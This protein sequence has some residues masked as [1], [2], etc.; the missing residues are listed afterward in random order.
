MA[1][2]CTACTKPLIID[3]KFCF[4]C[5]EFDR[6]YSRGIFQ[7]IY[8]DGRSDYMALCHNDKIFE[9]EFGHSGKWLMLSDLRYKLNVLHVELLKKVIKK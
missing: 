4:S 6:K 1:F 8:N 7:L 3:K 9:K 5:D 2:R